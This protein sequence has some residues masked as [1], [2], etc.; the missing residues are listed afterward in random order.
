MQKVRDLGAL[1]S[2]CVLFI[3]SLPSRL[4]DLFRKGGRKIVRTRGGRKSVIQTQKD[5]YTEERT[6]TVLVHTGAMQVQGRQDTSAEKR[7]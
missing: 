3:K 4:R 1:K 2:K 5:S 6:E 7:T